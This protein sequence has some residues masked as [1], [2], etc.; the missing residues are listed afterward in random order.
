MRSSGSLKVSVSHLTRE[1]F[2]WHFSTKRYPDG[3]Y[4]RSGEAYLRSDSDLDHPVNSVSG[5]WTADAGNYRKTV[6]RPGETVRL[7]SRFAF[8]IRATVRYGI[9]AADT[10]HLTYEDARLDPGRKAAHADFRPD[11]SPGTRVAYLY[12]DDQP[13]DSLHFSVVAPD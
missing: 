2:Q 11:D 8:P 12:F 5:T 3:G 4:L 9:R 10:S 6:F 13:M 7:H 1:D